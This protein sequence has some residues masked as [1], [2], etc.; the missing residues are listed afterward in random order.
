M[1]GS[2]DPDGTQKASTTEE[3]TRSATRIAIR[4]DS[5]CCRSR[6]FDG[7]VCGCSRRQKAKREGT[8]AIG[9]CSFMGFFLRWDMGIYLMME[10]EQVSVKG[11]YRASAARSRLDIPVLP[12]M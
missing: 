7:A 5:M 8:A 3:R 6:D 10:C 9:A 1:V 12:R 11:R 4:N 2:M